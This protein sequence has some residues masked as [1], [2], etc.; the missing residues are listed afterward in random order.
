MANFNF[1]KC[2]EVMK[3]LNWTWKDSDTSPNIS[4]LKSW[5]VDRLQTAYELASD[6]NTSILGQLY[7]S[8][9]G[10]LCAKCIRLQ[11]KDQKNYYFLELTF[12]LETFDH[13]PTDYN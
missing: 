1:K 3:F 12:E 2:H 10:G 13:N 7:F 11:D 9:S 6:L 5:A 4:E 8:S